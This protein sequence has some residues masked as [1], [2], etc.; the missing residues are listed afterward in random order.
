MKEKV[1]TNSNDVRVESPEILHLTDQLEDIVGRLG[2]SIVLIH[3]GVIN[4][5][6][7]KYLSTSWGGSFP[8]YHNNWNCGI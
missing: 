4:T 6:R 5:T 8:R 3:L 1:R 2:L 7:K